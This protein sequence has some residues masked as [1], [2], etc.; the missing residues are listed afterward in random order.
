[1][2]EELLKLLQ[3]EDKALSLNEIRTSLNIGEDKLDELLNTIKDLEEELK[4]RFTKKK[5]YY[6]EKNDYRTGIFHSTRKDYGFVTTDLKKDL[7]IP[8]RFTCNAING[9]KVV[10]EQ[11]GKK[12]ESIGKIVKVISHSK[13]GIVGEVIKVDGKTIVVPDNKK[14]DIRVLVNNDSDL[15]EGHKVLVEMTDNIKDKLFAGNIVKLIGHKDD[16]GIDI[17]SVINEFD[18]RYEWPEEIEK[19]TIIIPSM[20]KEKDLVNRRDLRKENIFA[21]DSETTK[22]RDDAISIKKLANGNYLLGVHIADV[23]NYVKEGTK[24]DTEARLRGNS[25]YL[26]DTSIPMLPRKLSNGICSLNQ[27]VD[28]L[29]VTCEME[30]NSKGDTVGFDIYESVINSKKDMTYTSVNK[31]IEED[32]I[33]VGYE[34]FVDDLKEMKNLADILREKRRKKGYQDFDLTESKIIVDETG[35]PIEIKIRPRGAGEKLIEDF[36]IAANE[37]VDRYLSDLGYPI[38]HRIHP[39]PDVERLEEFLQT[40]KMLGHKVTTKV[41]K[42]YPITMQS[43]LDEYEDEK[44]KE[45]MRELLLC[46]ESKAS[47]SPDNVGHFGLASSNYCHF[48]SPIRRYPDLSIHRSI[49]DAIKGKLYED[50]TYFDRKYI[51]ATDIGQISSSTE[52]NADA[53]EKECDNMKKAEYMESHIGEEYEGKITGI[54]TDGMFVRLDNTVKGFVRSDSFE[55]ENYIYDEKTL[56]LVGRTSKKKYRLGDKTIVLVKDASKELR[57]VDLVV[58]EDCKQLKKNRD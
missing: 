58:K 57:T 48:T 17:L 40:S 24:I 15:V 38:V 34:S 30:I 11:T 25:V 5:K 2:R 54:R 46:C 47:Y 32:E 56:S 45:L 9:D 10:V 1:M 21:I 19:E 29:T 4:L 18:I 22:D 51:D 14:I 55:S 41:D 52:R 37:T 44:D 12:E 28:R 6:L 26:V 3:E 23:S 39:A 13:T 20:V 43:I 49:K 27:D 35:K 7:Y 16:P 53:C 36:M 50:E 42:V 31:I 33:P 8:A